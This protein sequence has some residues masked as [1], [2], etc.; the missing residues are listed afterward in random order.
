MSNNELEDDTETFAKSSAKASMEAMSAGRHLH[1]CTVRHVGLR[2]RFVWRTRTTTLNSASGSRRRVDLSPCRRRDGS[3]GGQARHDDQFTYPAPVQYAQPRVAA[4][5]GGEWLK[6]SRWQQCAKP[7]LEP[8]RFG[9][10]EGCWW[11]APV[12]SPCRTGLLPSTLSSFSSPQCICAT[13]DPTR[14][15]CLK[16]VSH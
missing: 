3:W 12:M 10:R 5:D 16:T 4:S 15:R 2:T 7:P 14:V 9:A 6:L 13:T 1:D 8:E 11:F